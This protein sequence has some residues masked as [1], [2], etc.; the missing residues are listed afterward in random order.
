MSIWIGS[1]AL[2]TTPWASDENVVIVVLVYI[3]LMY[4]IN[5]KG[6]IRPWPC[7]RTTYVGVGRITINHIKIYENCSPYIF[8]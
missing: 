5:L 1:D 8:G 7:F 4:L 3:I 2:L 6:H